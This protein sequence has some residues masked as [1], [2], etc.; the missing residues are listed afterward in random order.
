VVE[1]VKR[2]LSVEA[3]AVTAAEVAELAVGAVDP[4]VEL[5]A[6]S[7]ISTTSVMG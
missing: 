2:T 6:V 7:V 4:G 1:A 5:Q 3:R